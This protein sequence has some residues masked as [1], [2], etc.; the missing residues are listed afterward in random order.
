RP[1]DASGA[2]GSS[3]RLGARE[4][5]RLP[6]ARR[7]IHAAPRS[8]AAGLQ[9]ADAAAGILL[10]RKRLG[11]TVPPR[12]RRRSALRH[13]ERRGG[14]ARRGCRRRS[15]ARAG[16]AGAAAPPGGRGGRLLA[17]GEA[18]LTLLPGHCVAEGLVD[19]KLLLVLVALLAAGGGA[20]ALRASD[21]NE[22]SLPDHLRPACPHVVPG[23][24][25]EGPLLDPDEPGSLE[26]LH[27]LRQR[28]VRP[29]VEPPEAHDGDVGPLL[30]FPRRGPVVVNLAAAERDPRRLLRGWVDDDA[31][32][33]PA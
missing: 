8:G 27:H 25:V 3:V 21:G 2:R 28:R 33:R 6:L 13:D 31:L 1:S 15:L 24:H 4:F 5:R 18:A 16:N 23:A 17:L 32:E 14:A 9:H 12:G 19:E 29:R 10:R 11:N 22:P 7:R 20:R 30:R 26:G